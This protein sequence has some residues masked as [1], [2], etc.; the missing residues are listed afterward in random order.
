MKEKRVFLI[1]LTVSAILHFYFIK[2][3]FDLPDKNSGE[4]VIPVTFIPGAERE[5]LS[6]P[7]GIEEK[8]ISLPEDRPEKKGYY[9]ASG[10]E[11]LLKLYLEMIAEE[12]DRRKFSPDESKYFGLIGNATV[13]FIVTGDGFFRDIVILNSSGDELLDRTALNAVAEVSGKVKRPAASGKNNVRVYIIV[14]YQY[15]L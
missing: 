11:R 10:R 6:E 8:Q 3:G 9:S 14:K 4:I 13:G 7:E 2:T 1:A 12:I 5:I 15:G